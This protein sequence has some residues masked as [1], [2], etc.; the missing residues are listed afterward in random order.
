MGVAIRPNLIMLH[1]PEPYF[2]RFALQTLQPFAEQ[3]PLGYFSAKGNI[4]LAYRHIKQNQPTQKLL[5]IA[6]GRAE[7]ILKWTEVA[8]NFYQWGYDILLFDHRGQGYSQRLLADGEKGYIDEFRFYMDDMAH[9]IEHI[10]SQSAYRQQYLLAHSMGALIS[11]FY[12]AHYPHQISKAV[13]SSPFFGIPYTHPWRDNL[14]VN[15]MM[16]LGQGKR[17]VFGK[18]PYQPANVT[19]NHLSHCRLRMT[20]HNRIQRRNQAI[21]LGGP[22]FRWLHLC[23]NAIAQLPKILPQI[24]TPTLVLQAQQDKVVNNKNL[25]KLTALLPQGQLHCFAQAKHELFFERDKL[26]Q[27]VV[28]LVQDF[29]AKP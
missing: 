11:S 24:E 19:D 17:Y 10:S 3:F 6:N 5:I 27:Q 29:F 8:Y 13:L 26:R 2:S 16:L 28:T 4:Q 20:W 7:N 22:T 1:N 21:R 12:L 9:L 23:H 18:Q 25:A 14:L 15:L